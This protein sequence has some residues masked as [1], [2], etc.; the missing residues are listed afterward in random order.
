MLLLSLK[1]YYD[2]VFFCIFVFPE[3]GNC[4]VFYLFRF[5]HAYHKFTFKQSP[6][7]VSLWSSVPCFYG[8][9]PRAPHPWTLHPMASLWTVC[10]RTMA[11]Y[12]LR[13]SHVGA[14]VFSFLISP[15]F[16]WSTSWGIASLQ[17]PDRKCLYF[18]LTLNWWSGWRI[19]GSSQYCWRG[20]QN[21]PDD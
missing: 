15:S 8:A 21:H 1:I 5:L 2:Y 11:S 6:D 19:L 10:S 12:S 17:K 13:N 9:P 18:P 20:V 7:R 4:F 3:V 14:H 16:W